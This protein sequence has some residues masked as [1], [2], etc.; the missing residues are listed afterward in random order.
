MTIIWWEDAKKDLDLIYEYLAELN[1]HYAAKVYNTILDE[2]DKL[3]NYSESL[4]IESLIESTK[5]HFRS[6]I[7]VGG[8]Y[9][10]IYFVDKERIIITHIWDCRRN[11]ETIRQYF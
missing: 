1:K 8:K 10:I 2:V 3:L 9:K 7:V 4:A 11:T 6:S 5:Y